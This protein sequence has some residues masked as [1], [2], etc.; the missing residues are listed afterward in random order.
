MSSLKEE[1]WKILKKLNWKMCLLK[2]FRIWNYLKYIFNIFGY[3]D[4]NIL[5]IYVYF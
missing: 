5:K 3:L 2:I 1:Y 4:I